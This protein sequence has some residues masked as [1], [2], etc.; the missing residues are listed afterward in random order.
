MDHY[1][2]DELMRGRYHVIPDHPQLLAPD[3]MMALTVPA[4]STENP[5]SA[6]IQAP[7]AAT[8]GSPETDES[9]SANSGQREM[10][11]AHE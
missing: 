7:S 10:K 1:P 5:E 6:G 3:N 9:A 8:G 4:R 11:V 2:R